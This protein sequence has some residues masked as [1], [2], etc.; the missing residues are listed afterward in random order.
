M[1]MDQV[2]HMD[3]DFGTSHA[4][5]VPTEAA[6]TQPFL[7]ERSIA[8]ER[9]ARW[10]TAGLTA[11]RI[12]TTDA[13]TASLYAGSLDTRGRL[14]LVLVGSMLSR[15]ESFHQSHRPD[16]L[17]RGPSANAVQRPASI[18]HEPEELMRRF[19]R[20]VSDWLHQA[21][22]TA[23]TEPL[24]VF[25]APRFLGYLRDA[26]GPL[27]D[28]IALYRGEFTTLRT[29]EMAAHPT[30]RLLAQSMRTETQSRVVRPGVDR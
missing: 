23:P 22:E 27:T 29:N 9:M 11:I 13:R 6:A 12:A 5:T 10:T 24:A 16:E 30:V 19:A 4:T 20:E 14:H 1:D 15:W 25:A 8:L 7:D 18:G 17:G 21:K 28:G 26:L 3:Q 2:F